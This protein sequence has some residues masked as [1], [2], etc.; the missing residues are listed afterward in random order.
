M[1]IKFTIIFFLTIIFIIPLLIEL[2]F[3]L[4]KRNLVITFLQAIFFDKKKSFYS[5]N[6]SLKSV[7]KFVFTPHPFL[8]WSLNPHYKNEHSELVHT[9]EGFRKTFDTDSIIDYI[10]ENKKNYKIVCIGGSSTHCAE[11]DDFRDTWP[12]LLHKNIN[13]KHK[14]TIIN[15]GVG[16]WSSIQSQIRCSTWFSK[17]KPN[18]L[19]FYQCKNDLTPLMNGSLTENEILPD[20]QN[21]VT[22]FSE[23][24]FV[25]MPRFFL[26][27]PLLSLFYFVKFTYQNRL[28]L[29]NIYKPK[30]EQNPLGMNRL[31]NDFID[32]IYFRHST[33]VQMCKEINCDVLY[34]PEIVTEGIYRDILKNDI[35]PIFEKKLSLKDNVQIFDIDP[36]IPK[37]K[38]FFIDKMHFTKKGNEFFADILSKKIIK[39]YFE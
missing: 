26:F 39:S 13:K 20:F 18:L 14:S 21:I 31:N 4:I 9:K 3:Y 2:F 36:L 5:K 8:N 12:S 7:D 32:S 6:N 16:A 11:M 22:Q 25:N 27:I 28:G 38:E 10:N 1:D 23:K 33:I 35:Y 29:L 37:S 24:F 34:I 15:F 17:I 30:A 19:I